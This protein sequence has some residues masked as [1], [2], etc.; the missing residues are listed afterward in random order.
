M[1]REGNIEG[2]GN[3]HLPHEG[4]SDWAKPCCFTNLSKKKKRPQFMAQ[5]SQGVPIGT[6]AIRGDIGCI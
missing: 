3:H 1:K 6:A 2:F 5:F 4:L